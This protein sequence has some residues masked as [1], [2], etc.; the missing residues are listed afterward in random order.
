MFPFDLQHFNDDPGDGGGE[1]TGTEKE[2][3]TD[4]NTVEL[5]QEQIQ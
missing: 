4:E 2:L 1:K 5:T 3:S